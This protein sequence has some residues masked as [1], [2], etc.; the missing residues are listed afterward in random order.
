MQMPPKYGAPFRCS[1]IEENNKI[2]LS[3]LGMSAEVDKFYKVFCK[4]TQSKNGMWE[5]RFF[6][7]GKL[8]PCWG[9]AILY[10]IQPEGLYLV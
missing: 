7:D 2:V 4:L 5:Q 10:H 8:A 6:S 9:Y 3:I 1:V